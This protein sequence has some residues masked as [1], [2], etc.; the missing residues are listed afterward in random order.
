[1]VSMTRYLIKSEILK[2]F[3]KF[4]WHFEAENAD[5]HHKLL[6]TDS[7]DMIWNLSDE[8][9]YETDTQRI[10]APPFHINGL[11]GKH[12]YIHHKGEIQAMGIAFYSYG[13]YPFVNKS[14]IPTQN[15]II[16]LFSFSE[17][18]SEQIKSVIMVN[19]PIHEK[20]EL[21]EKVLCSNLKLNKDETNK[22]DIISKFLKTEN[23]MTIQTFCKEQRI[24]VKTFERMVLRYT[25]YTPKL[26][27]RIRR[28]QT[29]TNQFVHRDF[30]KLTDVVYDN[31]FTDQPH[32]NR[33]FQG[34]SGVAPNI[35]HKQKATIKENVT[36][37][38][39]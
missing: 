27:S 8:I 9:Y 28:F 31:H 18:L 24:A 1:M 37:I 36:Y 20:I 10:T 14:L 19:K 17:P 4:I 2:P 3:V 16:D 13:L 32:F 25:G 35:F 29:A 6:P 38:Y 30:S 15:Q 11:R 21:V 12:S 33:E 23:D 5:I 34:F 39:G 26:L 22:I 7:I